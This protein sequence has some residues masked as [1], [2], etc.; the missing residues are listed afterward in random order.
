M[1]WAR[2]PVGVLD[3]SRGRREVIKRGVKQRE[4]A[5]RGG[6]NGV[7]ENRRGDERVRQ[8]APDPDAAPDMR[9]KT[10]RLLDGIDKERGAGWRFVEHT[11]AIA[12][13]VPEV[14]DLRKP[15]P[16]LASKQ[17]TDDGI[18]LTPQSL[19]LCQTREVLILNGPY[20]CFLSGRGSCAQVGLNVLQS[21]QFAEQ[22]TSRRLL[23]EISNAG[24]R[25]VKTSRRWLTRSNWYLM[26]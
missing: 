23:L 9:L 20:S 2:S 6:D 11:V 10:R 15:Q 3:H 12:G 16:R 21:S 18:V 7:V 8:M 13:L 26:E 22:D 19:I 1:N 17:M 4:I 14:V 24:S 5:K 25:K